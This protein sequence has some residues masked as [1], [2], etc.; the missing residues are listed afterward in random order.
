MTK[1]SLSEFA[2]KV[3][4]VMPSIMR[5][6]LKRQGTGFHKVKLT[7]PQFIVL[8]L[9]YRRRESKMTE[10]A[11]LLNVTTAAM[12]GIVDRLVR[13]GYAVRANEP[14]DRRI[15][16]IKL[17][18]KGTSTA[19]RILEER[20]RMIMKMFSVVSQAERGQYLKILEHI[21]Y[22]LTEGQERR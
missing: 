15:I 19:K 3:S 17:T 10:M 21:R 18:Q 11:R 7:P 5:E 20:R 8:D 22:H 1:I 13:D 16:K 6:F 9:L 2:D 4:E 14:A 12:T